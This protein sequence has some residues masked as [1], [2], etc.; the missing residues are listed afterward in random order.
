MSINEQLQYPLTL[1]SFNKERER[2]RPKDLIDFSIE[3]FKA[4]QNGTAFKYNDLSGL[5]KFI[6]N[7][8]D[9]EIIRRL[10]IPD[11]DLYRVRNRRK[12][13]TEQE[14]LIKFNE[15]LAS[16]NQIIDSSSDNQLS[17]QEMLNYLQFKKN[18]FQEIEFFRFINNLENISLENDR[19]I[20]FTKF[21]PLNQDQK[22]AIINLLSCD[23]KIIKNIKINDWKDY[24]IS[25]DKSCK[26]TYASYDKIGFKLEEMCKKIDNKEDFDF[27]EGEELYNSYHNL[28]ESLLDLNES[29]IYKIFISK[30]QFERIILFCMVK[31]KHSKNEGLNELFRKVKRIFNNSFAYLT[32]LDYYDFILNCFIPLLKN[33]DKTSQ[34]HREMESFINHLIPQIPYI[35]NTNFE[36]EKSLYYNIEC[37]KYFLNKE[38]RIH[39][40]PFKKILIDLIH[41]FAKKV[42]YLKERLNIKNPL[43]FKSLF[44]DKLE[45]LTLQLNEFY[46]HLISFTN[47]L[48]SIAIKYNIKENSEIRNSMISEFK[49]YEHIDQILITNSMNMFKLF[50]TESNKEKGINDV[51]ELLIKSL[52]ILEMNDAIK[53]STRNED[54][55]IQS[56]VK[57][58]YN[59][60][61]N[62]PRYDFNNLKYIKFLHQN[63]IVSLVIKNNKNLENSSLSFY[64]D[65]IQPFLNYNNMI[66]ELFNFNNLFFKLVFDKNM[67]DIIK[68]DSNIMIN[69][70][71]NN[72]KN[73]NQFIESLPTNLDNLEFIEKFKEFNDFQQK[74]ILTY[75]NVM[76]NIN[77]EN[78]YLDIIK[79]L[80]I[81]YLKPKIDF[82]SNK[83]LQ[84]KE[85]KTNIIFLECIYD[86]L[87]HV[88]YP[89]YIYIKYDK[90]INFF[91]S[92]TKEEKEIIEKIEKAQ[93]LNVNY[94]VPKCL[95]YQE[96]LESEDFKEIIIDLTN[97]HK[98]IN[99]YIKE[100][101]TE[102]PEA[103]INDF[104]LFNG[105]ERK[106]IIKILEKKEGK[107]V[108]ILK[109]YDNKNQ[110]E[111][112]FILKKI[113]TAETDNN[114]MYI[115]DELGND[116][117]IY[118]R[119]ELL[120]TE[121]NLSELKMNF[122]S[123]VLDYPYDPSNNYI[124]KN[125]LNFN[126][127][128]K[129]T[130]VEDILVRMKITNYKT[131][132]YGII[133]SNIIEEIINDYVD[134]AKR[135]NDNEIFMNK[136]KEEFLFL[137]HF[138][139]NSVFKFI[140]EIDSVENQTI[141]KFT[142]NFTDKERKLICI[143]LELY[144]LIMKNNRYNDYKEE[145]SNYLE[146]LT[147][148][149]RLEDI[150]NKLDKILKNEVIKYM[151]ILTAEE[152]KE[153]VL[154]IDYI[155]EEI[156]TNNK[157]EKLSSLVKNL[158][159]RL[160]YPER[161]IL[162]KCLKCIKEQ[163]N[164]GNI[165]NYIKELEEMKNNREKESV[166]SNICDSF[167]AIKR[168]LYETKDKNDI[169]GN[170]Q[171][172]KNT[173]NLICFDLFK[174][175]D[176]CK[177]GNINFRK[178]KAVSP[179]KV[180]IIKIL[181][182]IEN[183][184]N[185]NENLK[186]AINLLRDLKLN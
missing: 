79:N 183:M 70:F 93:R 14:I 117:K 145:L 44:K 118:Y 105:N 121:K 159:E 13:L 34:E 179:I 43:E 109:D 178:I 8:D 40:L 31:I 15:D 38:S 33:S 149:Q 186:N 153:T 11:E 135:H 28:F 99:E 36:E 154:E 127:Y 47:Q 86:D 175:V 128:E 37:V 42:S 111:N 146:D 49:S 122:I 55:I 20:Y 63:Q 4:L 72:F 32:V 71:K 168:V 97:N 134:I 181:L 129:I 35:Y 162:I 68:K 133:A 141:Y 67:K 142:N 23:I 16:F 41:I 114:L 171:K 45:L 132:F 66:D 163:N 83:I 166:F 74:L 21:F 182:E 158:F 98:L 113:V 131:L 143:F 90:D 147:Y 156:I 151:F 180:E 92:F 29:E 75:L 84:E 102:N 107:D 119:K 52:S 27:V 137:I 112:K 91:I 5:D 148:N 57:N 115:N 184:F 58:Y 100:Y 96:L 56:F 161:E 88:N 120:Q 25:M 140:L 78:K 60:L 172:L 30:Y 53:N 110:D 167:E 46:P 10:G 48:I 51:I 139:D 106:V 26:H 136:I 124:I 164:N 76:D 101:N 82:I 116:I 95:S 62:T 24:L 61:I 12:K 7:P 9:S 54:E 19:R 65:N 138:F 69:K 130:I 17:E 103:M 22:N 174:F 87:R 81:I 108:S 39:T 176:D 123:S 18:T 94:S 165:E 64:K 155:I 77:C 85:I 125:F 152:I 2:Y 3:Y 50:E 169:L 104:S 73:E 126:K 157:E 150:N 1:E 59:K 173:L 89:I 170:F 185:S 177:K 80:S 144:G 160:I 6:L